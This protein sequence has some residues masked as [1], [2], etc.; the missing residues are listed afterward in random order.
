LRNEELRY[1]SSSRI[2]IITVVDSRR[3]RWEWDTAH[4]RNKKCIDNF[5]ENN[6]GKRPLGKNRSRWKDNIKIKILSKN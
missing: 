6:E 5:V 3:M 4:I 2:L 1:S